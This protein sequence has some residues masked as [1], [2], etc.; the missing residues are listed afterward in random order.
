VLLRPLALYNNSVGC[1]DVGLMSGTMTATG[2]LDAAGDSI[3][4]MYVAGSF[5]PEHLKGREDALS[6]LDFLVV[7]ELF[8]TETTR[9]ADVVLPAA[10]A[11]E[12]DGTFTNNCGFV[13]RLRQS[14]PPVQQS[15]Q[16][17]VITAQ[18]ARALGA[19]FGWQ[20]S[21]S[22]VFK[23][24]AEHVPAYTGL[25]YP[26]LK[27][28]TKPV[29]ARH[30]VAE[31]LD[32]AREHERLLSRVEVMNETTAKLMETPPVGHEL[33]KLGT[34]T[35][36]TPQFHLLAAGNPEPPSVLISPLYQITVDPSLQRR[37]EAVAG[38]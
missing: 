18:V 3:R 10:S 11:Y 23:E 19:D 25:R 8:E 21:A 32:L 27:D 12:S 24:L 15:K 16:D 36:K 35:S 34:L 31:K 9:H 29:Q 20:M 22:A 33:F 26:L 5:L 2:M 6:R 38:D 4:A 7:Q 28:E 1:H 13:Q 17:W 14:V 30:A 37:T